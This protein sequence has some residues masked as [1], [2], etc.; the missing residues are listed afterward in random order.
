MPQRPKFRPTVAAK[1]NGPDA[2]L[3]G[4]VIL[5]SAGEAQKC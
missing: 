4:E 2:G 5:L 1:H 3:T